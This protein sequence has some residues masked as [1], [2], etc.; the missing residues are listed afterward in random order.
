[1]RNW[2]AFSEPKGLGFEMSYVCGC[3]IRMLMTAVICFS[4]VLRL[5]G[6]SK[7]RKVLYERD[8]IAVGNFV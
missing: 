6:F 8:L 1:M 4:L 2:I 7:L 5:I 3:C